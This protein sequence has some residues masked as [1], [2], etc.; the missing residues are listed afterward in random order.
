MS[1]FQPCITCNSL[2]A[3]TIDNTLAPPSEST[4]TM[5][6]VQPESGQ[7][8]FDF[9]NQPEQPQQQPDEMHLP[10]SDAEAL[11]SAIDQVVKSNLPNKVKL[12]DPDTFDGSNT[13]KLCTFILQCKLNF[14]DHS[15]L[16]QDDRMKV[17]Y[18]LSYLKGTALDCFEPVLLETPKP[19][20]LSDFALF[21]GELEASFSSYDPVGEAEAEL[22]GLCMQENHQATKYFIKFMQ[23]AARVQWGEAALLR[24]A[25]N[26]LAKRIKNDMVHH[27]KPTTLPGL[28][29]VRQA[30]DMRYWEHHTEVSR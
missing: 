23:L 20:W 18:M 22:E 29:K 24:Q 6:S 27:D 11:A 15:D 16:F 13:W 26:G 14:H 1:R 30:I 9:D 3:G 10:Q 4:P 7:H 8:P 28:R 17:N 21:L 2:C 19:M 25:Y 5:S 12:W